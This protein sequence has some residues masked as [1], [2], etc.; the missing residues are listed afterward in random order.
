MY[1]IDCEERVMDR[2]FY[3]KHIDN[4]RELFCLGGECHCW[5]SATQLGDQQYFTRQPRLQW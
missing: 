1:K 5:T 3:L 4:E 2:G